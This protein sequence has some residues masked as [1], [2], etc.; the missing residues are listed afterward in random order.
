MKGPATKKARL[1][2]M[3]K[4]ASVT[5]A[6]YQWSYYQISRFLVIGLQSKTNAAERETVSHKRSN[7]KVDE[8]WQ[9]CGASRW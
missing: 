2:M 9:V 6:S 8:S 3:A 5:N 7:K 1:C 4:R